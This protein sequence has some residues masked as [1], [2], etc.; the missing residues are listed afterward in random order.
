MLYP[1]GKILCSQKYNVEN[2]IYWMIV[3]CGKTYIHVQILRKIDKQIT[4]CY[5]FISE[6]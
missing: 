2:S 4:E 1:S 5:V 6:I 3:V